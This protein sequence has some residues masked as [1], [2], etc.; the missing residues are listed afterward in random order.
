ME[1]NFFGLI[2]RHQQQQQRGRARPEG[3][4]SWGNYR[5]GSNNANLKKRFLVYQKNDRPKIFEPKKMTEL[6]E[7]PH[8]YPL[9]KLILNLETI[10][11]TLMIC[12]NHPVNNKL[13]GEPEKSSHF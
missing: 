6:F 10:T 5:H 4:T 8:N 3:P 1:Q 7:S 9:V 11:A 13:P 12:Q 2:S